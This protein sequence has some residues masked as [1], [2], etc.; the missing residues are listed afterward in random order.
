M[1]KLMTRKENGEEWNVGYFEG[2][3]LQTEKEQETIE[4]SNWIDSMLVQSLFCQSVTTN[5][6]YH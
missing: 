3:H 6:N 2:N 1:K 4:E 5:C